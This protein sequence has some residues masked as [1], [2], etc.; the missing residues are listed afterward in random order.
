MTPLTETAVPTLDA[1]ASELRAQGYSPATV[2][3]RTYAL[4]SLCR[5]ADVEAHELTREDVL[6]WLG[7]ANRA[8]W[9][10]VKYLEHVKSWSRWSGI[11]GLV[12][13]IRKPRAPIGLPRPV[14]EDALA[15]MLAVARP[16]PE[17]AWLLLGAYCGLR[18]HESAKVCGSD[19]ELRPSGDWV[20]R[21]LGKGQQLAVVP[22][23]PVVVAELQRVAR[24]RRGRLWPTASSARVQVTV[25]RVAAR[26]GVVCTSHQ[27]RHRYGTALYGES[28]D[29][30]LTQQAMRHRSPATTAGYALVTAD[31]VAQVAARLPGAGRETAL[32]QPRLYVVR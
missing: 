20:L 18:A 22:C 17:L 8:Q 15:A 27:L 25:R 5:H 16:G 6:A 26:A 24:G 9:T 21:V 14:G 11:D 7:A 2:R 3:A 31:R 4:R 1:W 28:R 19:L 23:P 32:S 13:G 12:D 29:L 30:L 10:R